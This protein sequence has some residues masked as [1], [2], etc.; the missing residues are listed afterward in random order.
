MRSFALAIIGAALALAA[1]PLSAQ[2]APPVDTTKV[3]TL[4]VITVTAS[5]GNRL[6]RAAEL[7]KQIVELL[8][9]NRRLANTLRRD[10]AIVSRLELRLDS[11]RR[12]EADRQGVLSALTDSIS[13]TRARN[14]ALE[15]RIQAA[16]A[17]IPPA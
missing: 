3:A 10:D 16:E 7:R 8:A 4:P 12:V 2:T 17:R 5:T 9:E 14:R 15:A 13:E 1:A 11:L 6:T